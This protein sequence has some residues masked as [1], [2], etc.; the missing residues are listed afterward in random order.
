[1]PAAEVPPELP[2]PV[3]GIN[4]A[5][6]GMKRI[7]WLQLCAVHSDS[8]LMAV[9]FFFAARFN[10]QGRAELFDLVNQHPT[11]YEVVTGRAGNNPSKKRQ[12]IGGYAAEA[13]GNT[14]PKVENALAEILGKSSEPYVP[15]DAPSEEG[16]PLV[17]EDV[18]PSLVGRKAELLW[19]DDAKWYLIVFLELDVKSRTAKVCYATGEEEKLSLD[20]VI[21]N[22]E[23]MLLPSS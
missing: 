16:R 21:Q 11:V 1:M 22:K 15:A 8:W 4:F 9:L 18:S 20:E 2:E 6:Q 10:A 23:L 14:V 7:D 3:L 19:P 12:H 5:R 17:L 13:M